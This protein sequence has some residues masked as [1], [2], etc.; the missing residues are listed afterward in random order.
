MKVIFLKDVKGSGKAGEIK[1]VADGYARNYLLAKGLAREAD[2]A[3]LS[4]LRT[5][6]EAAEY[7]KETERAENQSI[8]DA[9]GGKTV[10]IKAKAGNGGKLF[11]AV[12]PAVVAEAVRE[13]YGQPI[14]K[15]KVTLTRGDIKAYGDYEAA[16]KMTQGVSFKLKVT[17]TEE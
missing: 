15:K 2:K 11:G 3:G 1:N 5:K 17:V 4:E 12:T 9:L 14:D 13:Q 8:A 10:V 6:K 7:K 16:V